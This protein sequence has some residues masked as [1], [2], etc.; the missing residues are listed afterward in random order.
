MITV[1][2]KPV[3]ILL[4]ED[5][6]VDKEQL[7]L[8]LSESS[9]HF[10][11]IEYAGSVHAALQML[12]E[13]RFDVVLLDLN[14]PDSKG[15]DSLLTVSQE[16]PGV[17][18]VI[19]G[20]GQEED[21]ALQV[22]ASNAQ[23]YL[24]KGK[25][26]KHTLAKSIYFAIERKDLEHKLWLAEDIYAIF[27]NSAVAITMADLQGRLISWNRFAERLLGMEKEDLRRIAVEQLYPQQEWQKI[28]DLNLRKRGM[29]HHFE[30]KMIKKDGSLIDVDISLSVLKNSQGRTVGSIG[31]IKDITERKRIREILDRKQKNLQAIFDAVPVG[32][33][34]IDPS[35]RVRR[36]NYAISQMLGKDYSDIIDQRLGDVLGCINTTC[37]GKVDACGAPE[38]TC[39]LLKT[40]KSTID[41]GR[42]ARGVEIQHTFQAQNVEVRPWLSVST[43]P[44]TI[45]GFNQVLVVINDITERKQAEQKLKETTELKSQFVSTVSHE[46]RTPLTCVKEAIAVILDG[47]AG[48]VTT[49]QEYFLNIAKKNI[50]RL[51]GLVNDV[52]DFQK[53]E[54]GRMKL[55]MRDNDIAEVAQ[56]AYSTLISLAEKKGLDFSIDLENDLP[57]AVFDGDKIIQV[58][59]NLLSNAI[60]FTPAPGRVC[61]GVRHR[62]DQLVIAVSDTGI[63]IPKDALPKIFERFY[64]V[65]RPGK[66]SQGTGLGLAI[67]RQIVMMHGGRIEVESEVDKGTTFTVWLPLVNKSTRGPTS[68]NAERLSVSNFATFG[69]S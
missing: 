41:S 17:A 51:A 3:R 64:R 21:S 23:E 18:I 50:D 14:L 45:D 29:E 37:R 59:T 22:I 66:Q 30:T 13:N 31:L 63:G 5:D 57:K 62:G 20:N 49:Q 7:S 69:E 10:A 26:D 6:P 54:A 46:L 2:T 28:R 25:F 36:V 4:V 15:V 55:D 9:I 35:L 43:E 40:I 24:V 32:M 68:E 8:S 16:H 34:L 65:H 58:L 48:N 52:L 47:A 11:Q 56:H 1:P 39:Q 33:L 44:I 61:L 38:P 42:F 12:G 27:E 67:T 53:L 60:K 19:I